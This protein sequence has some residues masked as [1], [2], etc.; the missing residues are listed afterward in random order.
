MAANIRD[1]NLKVLRGAE[2]WVF[3]LDN[4]LYDSSTDLFAQIDGRMRSFIADFLDLSL[5][6][7]R[8][9]QKSYFQE[10]GTTLNGMMKR[11]GMEPGPFLEHVH[12]IDLSP[13]KEDPALNAALAGL[14]GRKFIYTNASLGHAERII[15]RL[16]V[17]HHFEAVFDIERAR[18]VPKP[19]PAS[20]R[21][22]IEGLDLKPQKTVMV[23]DIALNL[24]PAAAMGMTTVW[25]RTGH[26]WGAI[27]SDQDY[28]HHVA[29]DLV[30]WLERV[31]GGGGVG[32]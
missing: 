22:L 2:A 24:E 12:D 25:V 18:Y 29:D 19:D 21:A 16:G 9:I 26:Q 15:E 17:T 14:D 31:A 6:E 32:E 4:T 13:I 28:V 8:P 11:H 10:Y 30:N 1:S 3:D 7:A 27:G 5:E 20:Y 23:E